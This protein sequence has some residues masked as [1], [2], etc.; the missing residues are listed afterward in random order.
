MILP[1]VKKWLD[2][3]KSK[4]FFLFIHCFDIHSPYDP[5]PP[6]NS[7]F[8]DFTYTG[9]LVP[10]TKNLIAVIKNNATINDEDLRHFIALYD[11]G[12]RYA[13]E[14]IG[15]LLSY[16]RDSGLYDRSLITL[17][18]DHGEE[19]KEHGSMGHW[20]LYHRPD[21]HVPLIMHIPHYPRNGIKI[22]ELV[23]SI[24][25][26]PTVLDECGASSL[27]TSTGEKSFPID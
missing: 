10:N 24:D 12:I 18:S 19:F 13:D 2:E 4:P 7:I 3:N 14:K 16:L 22:S 6:Y 23:R 1:K 27:C 21:L 9:H 25:L 15:D 11:G 20:Q 8:H 5:P 17:T 26:L